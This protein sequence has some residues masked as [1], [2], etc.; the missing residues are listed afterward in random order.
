MSSVEVM[1][2]D[3]FARGSRY[4]ACDLTPRAAVLQRQPATGRDIG[5][6]DCCMCSKRSYVERETMFK[7]IVYRCYKRMPV[8]R[9]VRNSA[10]MRA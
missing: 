8:S 10:A 5:P 2:L 6:A 1:N 3:H 7:G 4:V 9:I